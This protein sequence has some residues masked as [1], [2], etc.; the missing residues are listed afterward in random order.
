VLAG[1]VVWGALT[2]VSVA[3]AVLALVVTVLA[4]AGMDRVL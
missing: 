4:I 2:L 3:L 1:S